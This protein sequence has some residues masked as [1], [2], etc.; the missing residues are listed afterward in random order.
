MPLGPKANSCGQRALAFLLGPSATTDDFFARNWGKR[1]LVVRGGDHGRYAMFYSSTETF[2]GLIR[3]GGL[4]Q[5]VNCHWLRYHEG[6]GG[7]A[8]PSPAQGPLTAEGYA[9][10]LARGWSL[11]VLQPQ[12]WDKKIHAL[13]ERMENCFNSTVG[14]NLVHIAKDSRGT[15]KSSQLVSSV[16]FHL[17]RS[18]RV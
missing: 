16:I 18:F 7:E 14:A 4:H 3:K 9:D 17:L 11:Q 8:P 12:Q 10:G 2:H 13:V 1:P 15:T 6:D 5:G